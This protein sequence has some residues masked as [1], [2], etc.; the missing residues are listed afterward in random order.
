MR[1]PNLIV[2]TAMAAL[3]SLYAC[4]RGSD[5]LP[6]E[7][8]DAPSPAH[9]VP[10]PPTAA[11]KMVG[12][13]RTEAPWPSVAMVSDDPRVRRTALE[14]WAR[15]PTESLDLVTAAM[16]DPEES[17]R[18]RAQQIFD[19]EMELRAAGLKRTKASK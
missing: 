17:I 16:V 19:N 2:V 4:G 7:P 12:P 6:V 1:P 14:D 11:W 3:V 18:E 5:R 13:A 8:S 10:P 9:A 15:N